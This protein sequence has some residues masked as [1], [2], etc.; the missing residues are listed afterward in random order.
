MVSPHVAAAFLALP[1]PRAL[2]RYGEQRRPS[3]QVVQE[4]VM[5]SVTWT[6]IWPSWPRSKRRRSA[7]SFRFEASAFAR[8]FSGLGAS[9]S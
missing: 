2:S 8:P 4:V 3:A 7:G 5:P 9:S 1:P 6:A